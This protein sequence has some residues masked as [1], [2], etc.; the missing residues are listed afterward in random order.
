MA[1]VRS[2]AA[3]HKG[4]RYVMSK[5]GLRLG[6]TDVRDASALEQLKSLG[7]EMFT[8]LN[9]HVHTENEHTLRHL[10]ERVPGASAHDRSDHEKLDQIQKDLQRRML[11]LN[12][13]ETP[14]ELHTLYLNFA[15]FQS[16]YFEHIDEEETV[17]ERLLQ[18]HFSDAELIGHRHAIMKRLAPATLILWLKY[19]VP[20]Q[21]VD[22][23]I[24][25]LSGL[26][27]NAPQ[28]L[29]I[30]VMSV[31]STEMEPERYRELEALLNEK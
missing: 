7:V 10:E 9:D 28:E 17:T 15:L 2:F 22:E 27:A 31:I 23:S 13:R 6:Q 16:Q 20:A 1:T 3:P 8:L 18:S 24:S 25:M 29:F 12:G 30:E 14:D 19:I 5:F 21:R 26:K 4:L 11:E